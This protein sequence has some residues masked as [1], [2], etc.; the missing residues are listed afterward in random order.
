ML[1]REEIIQKATKIHDARG[2][3]CDRKYLFSCVNFATAILDTN[4]E[5]PDPTG[6]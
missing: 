2:C 4:K 1:T 5:D 3:Q 6:E